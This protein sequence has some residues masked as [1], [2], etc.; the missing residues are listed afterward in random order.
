L[1]YRAEDSK[2]LFVFPGS[3]PEKPLTDVKKSWLTICRCAG[4]SSTIRN[5]SASLHRR[6]RPVSTISSRET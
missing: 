2:S 6:R 5:F 1:K 4:L 3:D